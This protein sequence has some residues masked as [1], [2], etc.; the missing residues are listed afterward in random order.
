MTSATSGLDLPPGFRA[1]TLRESKDAMA[2]AASIAASEGAGTLVWVRRFDL[3]EVALVLEPDEPLEGARRALYACMNA[4]A[5]ALGAHCPPEKP[6]TF[7]WPDTILLD[8]G[9]IG[10]ARLLAPSGAAETA[11]LDWLVVGIM[12]RTVV[13]V[14]AAAMPNSGGHALDTPFVRGTSLETEGFEIID[15]AALIGSFCRHFMVAV[16]T[17]QEQ[18]FK[19]IGQQFLARVPAEKGVTRGIDGNGDLLRRRLSKAADPERQ[20]LLTALGTPGW[21][22]PETGAPWL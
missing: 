16:D 10:G 6:I 21:L 1:I 13:A 14:Q 11:V 8:D 9:I 12:L 4:A 5:D 18:G 20:S 2:H 22:D 3:V 17:W 19:P 15:P 7:A